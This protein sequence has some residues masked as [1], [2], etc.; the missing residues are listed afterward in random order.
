MVKLTDATLIQDYVQAKVDFDIEAR[1]N[2]R[3][4]VYFY[5]LLRPNDRVICYGLIAKYGLQGM[6]GLAFTEEPADI[7]EREA[8]AEEKAMRY[9][10]G[11]DYDDLE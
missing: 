5:F 3:N 4:A 9:E 11:D 6:G 2:G 1:F 8:M 7:E 10:S